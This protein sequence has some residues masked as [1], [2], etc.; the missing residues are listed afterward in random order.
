M[1]RDKA[2]WCTAGIGL[3]LHHNCASFTLI[4]PQ[5]AAGKTRHVTAHLPCFAT[6]LLTC[7]L[8]AA[9][10]ADPGGHLRLLFCAPHCGK[11]DQG[12]TAL[13]QTVSL[14]YYTAACWGKS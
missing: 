9:A 11:R 8:I 14:L 6:A 3:L 1:H 13:V 12:V 7:C 4:W 10:A 5:L 2:V